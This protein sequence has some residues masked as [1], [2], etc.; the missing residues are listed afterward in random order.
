MAKETDWN[1]YYYYTNLAANQ[2]RLRDR[3]SAKQQELSDKIAKLRAAQRSLDRTL[4]NVSMVKQR[5]SGVTQLNASEF[6]G[7]K[8]TQF[9]QKA[10]RM[11]QSLSKL[12]SKHSSN[13]DRIAS[14]IRE[15]ESSLNEQIA[16]YNSAS[17]SMAYFTNL[18]QSFL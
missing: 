18:A 11:G 14:K 5:L 13:R 6:Q 3:S 8:A 2:R 1:S 4:S 16:R 15:L 10:H 17:S 9:L 7:Q 12:H